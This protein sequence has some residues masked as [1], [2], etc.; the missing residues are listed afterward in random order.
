[1]KN[2]IF[3]CIVVMMQVLSGVT[4]QETKPT[5]D[6]GPVAQNPKPALKLILLPDKITV[7]PDSKFDLSI[8]WI[9]Q[10]NKAVSCMQKFSSNKIDENYVYDVRNSSGQP[11]LRVPNKGKQGVTPL[12]PCGVGPGASFETSVGC[13]MCAF[14]MRKPG[15]YTVQVSRRDPDHPGRILGTSNRV[16]VTVIPKKSETPQ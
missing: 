11:V 4:G 7:T 14:E 16:T 8:K 5:P 15:V 6:S 1:M 10:S 12:S 2:I 13:V 9:S 3:G